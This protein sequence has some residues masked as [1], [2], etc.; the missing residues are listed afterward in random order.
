M[1]LE[2]AGQAV[3]ATLQTLV[4]ALQALGLLVAAINGTSEWEDGKAAAD[5][6]SICV[7]IASA[8]IMLVSLADLY[9]FVRMHVRLWKERRDSGLAAAHVAL[10]SDLSA[11]ERPLMAMSEEMTTVSSATLTPQ[12]EPAGASTTK[13]AFLDQLLDER[14]LQQQ[15]EQQ[16]AQQRR[17]AAYWEELHRSADALLRRRQDEQ[18]SGGTVKEEP[19]EPLWRPGPQAAVLTNPLHRP[20]RAA[21]TG[22]AVAAESERGDLLNDLLAAVQPTRVKD[23]LDALLDGDPPQHAVR[24]GDLPFDL[25]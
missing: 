1:K 22:S 12:P 2:M 21:S 13:Q 24:H 7:T 6:A 15:Q 4:A 5:V 16:E 9:A 17:Q 8:L 14:T 3:V 20:S 25:L 19:A 10:L 11:I 23:D 18:I